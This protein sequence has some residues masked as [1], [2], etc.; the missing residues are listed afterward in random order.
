[1]TD[2]IATS[3]GKVEPAKIHMCN[4]VRILR[5]NLMELMLNNQELYHE[6]S[7]T[8]LVPLTSPLPH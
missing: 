3:I 8:K 6:S 7:S 1:M 2:V 5:G 4:D